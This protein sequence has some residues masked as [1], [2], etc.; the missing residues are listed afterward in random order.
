[1]KLINKQEVLSE[2]EIK[3]YENI[4]DETRFMQKELEKIMESFCLAQK[5]LEITD[6]QKLE[7]EKQKAFETL[8]I[9]K[10]KT[11]NDEIDNIESSDYVGTNS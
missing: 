5:S 3:F 2:L 9:M 1:M 10:I 7:I 11:L 4:E 8:D 6:K